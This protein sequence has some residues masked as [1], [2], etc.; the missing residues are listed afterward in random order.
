MIVILLRILYQIID[1]RIDR[2]ASVIADIQEAAQLRQT[3][4]G[5]VEKVK[6]FYLGLSLYFATLHN[7]TCA[8]ESN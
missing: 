3:K 1:I 8:N 7:L 4:K 5:R 2:W 6:K